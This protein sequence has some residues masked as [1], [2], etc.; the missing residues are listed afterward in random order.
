MIFFMILHLAGINVF[1]NGFGLGF[2]IIFNLSNIIRYLI[3]KD[4]NK[5]QDIIGTLLLPLLLLINFYL[6]D[7]GIYI[8]AYIVVLIGIGLTYIYCL[9][10]LNIPGKLSKVGFLCILL[11]G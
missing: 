9:N 1:T 3:S 2:L 7:M 6:F 4:R 11:I 10:R 5:K 8:P